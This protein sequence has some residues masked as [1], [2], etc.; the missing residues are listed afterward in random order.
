MSEHRERFNQHERLFFLRPRWIGT[1]CMI[2]GA[3]GAAYGLY[4]VVRYARHGEA[5]PLLFG[6]TP[7]AFATATLFVVYGIA[8]FW[9]GW[10]TRER[11]IQRLPSRTFTTHQVLQLVLAIISSLTLITVALIGLL[12]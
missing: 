2:S 9:D 3:A 11:T 10:L 12:K 4:V 7:M 5:A 1:G 6:T 8:I